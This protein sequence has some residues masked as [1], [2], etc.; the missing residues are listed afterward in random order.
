MMIMCIG[1][2]NDGKLISY[3]DSYISIPIPEPMPEKM[4][5]DP[6]PPISPVI[7]NDERYRL[8]K[9]RFNNESKFVYIFSKL[10]NEEVLDEVQKRW[11]QMD[12]S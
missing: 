4:N 3:M 10:T 6:S 1:G 5:L 9:F 12:L 7:S 2:K 11:H 8:E